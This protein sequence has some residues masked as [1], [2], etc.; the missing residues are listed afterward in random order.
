VAHQP[1]Q[2]RR[3]GE[4]LNSPLRRLKVR[5]DGFRPVRTKAL[6][7]IVMRGKVFRHGFG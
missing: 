1:Q 7:T 3:G 5:H 4:F 2:R 6:T